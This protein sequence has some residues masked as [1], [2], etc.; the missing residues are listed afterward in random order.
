M[1]AGN[2][3]AEVKPGH[4]RCEGRA[5]TMNVGGG[6]G[7]TAA[8]KPRNA[9]LPARHRDPAATGRTAGR[10]GGCDPVAPGIQTRPHRRDRSA[11][12]VGR[13]AIIRPLAD[14][15]AAAAPANPTR[16][17]A[18]GL[19]RTGFHDSGPGD[20]MGVAASGAGGRAGVR[21]E[22]RRGLAAIPTGRMIAFGGSATAD[23]EPGGIAAWITT[24]PPRGRAVTTRAISAEMP[25]VGM[26]GDTP[27]K[28][29]TQRCRGLR[30]A[31]LYPSGPGWGSP[32]PLPP[33]PPPLVG[34]GQLTPAGRSWR[35]SVGRPAAGRPSRRDR[36]DRLPPAHS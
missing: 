11:A 28:P 24:R 27:M 1:S 7:V 33:P 32:P 35:S 31:M 18:R 26:P 8:G 16:Q 30:R 34:I 22:P 25:V 15:P 19:R 10:R 3:N 2:R 14:R 29:P 5:V 17:I 21:A 13:P 6:I 23:V 12:V 36:S 20:G 4:A 9:D